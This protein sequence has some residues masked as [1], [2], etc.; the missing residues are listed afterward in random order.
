M[1]LIGQAAAFLADARR[2]ERRGP[3]MAEELRPADNESALAIQS[4]VTHMLGW[5]VGGWKASVPS[6]GRIL[7]AP[8]YA[9]DLHSGPECP[10]VPLKGMAPIEPEIA[11]VMARDLQPGVSDEEVVAAIGETRLV[12]ELIGSRFAEPDELSYPEKLADCLNNQALLVGPLC[13]RPIGDWMS[14]FPISIPGVF[15]RQGKHPDGHP[16]APLKWL[17]GQ[18]PLHAGQIVTTGSFA[19]VIQAPLGTPLRVIFGD[20]GEIGVTFTPR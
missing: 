1:D 3:R 19:G 15:E 14:A 17:A 6:K 12:L 5:P 2:V 7:M 10:I 11:F 4:R 9:R 18:V 8:I 20:A 16:L 13:G